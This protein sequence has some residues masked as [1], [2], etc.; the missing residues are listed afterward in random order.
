MVAREHITKQQVNIMKKE[1][2][3]KNT[4]LVTLF[5]EE[6]GDSVPAAKRMVLENTIAVGNEEM[7]EEVL[8]MYWGTIRN[9]GKTIERFPS[10]YGRPSEAYTPEQEHNR[11]TLANVVRSVFA[12]TPTETQEILLK[13]WVPHGR[14]GGEYGSW[15]DL[16]EDVV[17]GRMAYLDKAMGTKHP[18]PTWDGLS[19][20]GNVPD[21][22]PTEANSASSDDTEVN[23]EEE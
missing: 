9:M 7:D 6:E 3:N 21:I 10:F 11:N 15:E 4:Q 23:S 5:L 18:L 14:T 20:N 17:R 13:I 8:G 2:W 16:V 1:N 19:F 22:T 12:E